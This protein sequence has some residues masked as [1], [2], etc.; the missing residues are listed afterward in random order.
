MKQWLRS[1]LQRLIDDR[2]NNA[3]ILKYAPYRPD[4]TAFRID[5][6]SDHPTELHRGLP[7]PPPELFAGYGPTPEAYVSVAETHVQTMLRLLADTGFTRT[8]GDRSL[9]HG[10]AA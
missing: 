4:L 3:A 9:D 10:C 2:T 1:R 7:I 6:P 8:K 5:N